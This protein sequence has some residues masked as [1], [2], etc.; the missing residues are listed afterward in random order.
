MKKCTKEYRFQ[1]RKWLI[2][3][4]VKY[5]KTLLDKIVLKSGQ[6]LVTIKRIIYMDINSV[7]Y[8]RQETKEAIC[9][10]FEKPIDQLETKKTMQD[11]K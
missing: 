9:I 2:D 4:P 7:Q 3:L 8:V 5:R 1:V 10:V 6:S 11:D